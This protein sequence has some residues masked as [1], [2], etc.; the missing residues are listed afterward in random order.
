MEVMIKMFN[1]YF[2]SVELIEY[3]NGYYKGILATKNQQDLSTLI[4]NFSF[5]KNENN[6]ILAKKY[7]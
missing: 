6:I 2:Q 3:A 7:H 1:K 5:N 4:S